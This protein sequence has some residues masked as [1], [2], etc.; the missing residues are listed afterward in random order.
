LCLEEFVANY[1][2]KIN[3]IHY[4][5][6]IICWVSFNQHK[7]PKNHYRELLF[8]FKPFQKSELNLQNNY[9]SWKH[10]YMEQKNDLEKMRI[11]PSKI[12]NI[13]WDNLESQ[14]KEYTKIH[15][16]NGWEIIFSNEILIMQVIHIKIHYSLI[17]KK[18]N[19]MMYHVKILHNQKIKM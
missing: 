11:N 8:L 7:N 5:S 18:L 10:A 12:F 14:V 3:K 9:D 6:K 1:D 2:T 19:H 4:K 17:P 13:E 15:Q 16:T